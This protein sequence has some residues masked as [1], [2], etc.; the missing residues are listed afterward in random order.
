MTDTG[1][2][3]HEKSTN[4]NLEPTKL[5]EYR[6]VREDIVSPKRSKVC[7]DNECQTDEMQTACK[8][9]ENQPPQV[10]KVRAR[11]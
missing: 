2:I 7:V 9:C 1:Q 11:A 5:R 3:D 4:N 10:Q 8:K 6:D